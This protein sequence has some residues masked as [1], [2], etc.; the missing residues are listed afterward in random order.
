MRVLFDEKALLFCYFSERLD[1]HHE[2][3][4]LDNI[5]GY[6]L[7]VLVFE[8]ANLSHTFPRPHI[9]SPIN[10]VAHQC[11]NLMVSK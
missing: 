1:N 9:T 11:V 2:P 6:H 8:G 10:Y 4:S 5:L 7:K 3:S